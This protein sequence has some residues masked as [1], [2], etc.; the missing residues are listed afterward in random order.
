MEIGGGDKDKD[1]GK[2]ETKGERQNKM[3]V[4]GGQ[5]KAAVM[6]KCQQCQLTL[7]HSR[8][9][10]PVVTIPDTDNMS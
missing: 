1:K 6:E 10:F 7:W 2:R 9:C 4:G 5:T 8:S 3:V